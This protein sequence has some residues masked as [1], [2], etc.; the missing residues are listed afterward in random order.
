M[1]KDFLLEIITEE[2]PPKNIMKIVKSFYKNIINELKKKFIK[3]NKIIWYATSR[4]LAIKINKLKYKKKYIEN[5]KTKKIVKNKKEILI[6]IIK[7]IKEIIFNSI[8]KLNLVKVMYW[9]D[10]KTKFIRPIRNIL[11]ILENKKINLKILNIKSKNYTLGN[12]FIKN[13]KKIYLKNVS[14]YKEK[15]KKEGKVIVDSLERK[16]TMLK[17]IKKKIKKIDGK[18][19]LNKNFLEEINYM[20]EW[21]NIYIGKFNNKF[22]NIYTKLIKHIVETTQKCLIIY[23]KSNNITNYFIIISNVSKKYSYRIKID[24]ENIINEKLRD[25]IFFLHLDAKKK[26]IDNLDKLKKH[27]FHKKLG[28]FFEKTIRIKKISCWIS[29]KI[30]INKKNVIQASLLSKCDLLTNMVFEFPE[31]QGY[32][33]MKYAM[34]EKK[35]KKISYAIKE[36]YYPIF[37]NSKIPK[38]KISCIISISDKIDTIVG[39]FISGEKPNSKNDPFYI[40]KNAY[41]IIRILL[42]KKININLIKLIKISINLYKK[43]KINKIL[44]KEIIKYFEKKILSLLIKKYNLKKCF[45]ISSINTFKTIPILIYKN[46]LEISN[47]KNI[48]NLKNTYKRISNIIKNKKIFKNSKIKEK[49]IN[50]NIEKK[51]Y[52]I[53]VIF[54]KNIKNM[55]KKLK[56]KHIFYY[57]DIICKI[58]NILF[59]KIFINDKNKKIRNNRILLLKKIKIQFNKIIKLKYIF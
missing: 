10:T 11:C 46:T 48:E 39:L 36:Q 4:R 5:I 15:I 18:L 44:E 26:L 35:N 38:Y 52:F 7:D 1:K 54:K 34:Q 20:I 14:D 32:I 17:E 57:I 40:R 2:L 59:K 58:T 53:L 22:L 33:G 13:N 8:K 25:I 6:K 55:I 19:I 56:Y 24:N 49:I 45:I 42:E 3:Y 29:K 28:T 47:Y 21:P 50:N 23:S 37:Y 51:L 30:K 16:R 12:F 43:N 31:M 41:G 9:N 27:I